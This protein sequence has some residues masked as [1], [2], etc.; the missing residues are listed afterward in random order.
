MNV[1][2]LSDAISPLSLGMPGPSRSAQ[3]CPVRLAITLLYTL[4][5][6]AAE[7]SHEK[8]C[9]IPFFCSRVHGFVLPRRSPAPGPACPAA[10]AASSR[11]TR[12]RC[13]VRSAGCRT[14]R[15]RQPAHRAHD[16]HRAVAQAVHLVQAARLEARR[17]QEHV[18]AGLD[19]V[20]EPLVEPDPRADRSGRHGASPC[21]MSW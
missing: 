16:R 21:H 13:P 14:H 11:R 7:R 9:R 20:R 18:S 4:T 15:V 19:Q 2:T 6:S 8:S 12:S 1:F 3:A 5:Y 10:P 17:H